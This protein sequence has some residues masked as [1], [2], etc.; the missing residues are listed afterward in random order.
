MLAGRGEALASR[1]RIVAIDALGHGQSDRL[2]DDELVGEGLDAAAA[3]MDA[4]VET[5]AEA[6]E[7]ISG[8]IVLIGHSMGGATAA[9]VAATRPD[10]LRGVDLEEPAWQELS[11]ERWAR[12]GAAWVAAARGD[13]ENPRGS[14]ERDLADP[15]N[16][17]SAPE[18]EAWVD[19]HTRFDDRFVG[20]GRTEPTHPW[21]E[22][23]ST[24]E[25]PTLIVTG[26]DDVIIDANVRQE[27]AEIGNPRVRIEVVRGA[28]H[29][30]R[31]DRGDAYHAVV[32]PFIASRFEY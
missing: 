12:R 32:D 2:R 16:L 13:R 4:L 19:A 31:R 17:W 14:V 6:I 29:S 15:A 23:A 18:I 22:L 11:A 30:V 24:I 10:L 1:Y 3:A 7:A 9:V 8:P 5:T 26:S 21:R 27:V 28:G 20:I 25:I